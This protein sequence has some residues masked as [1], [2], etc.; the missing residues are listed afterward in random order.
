MTVEYWNSKSG[1]E[2]SI[3]TRRMSASVAD[4]RVD[5]NAS[6]KEW[7]RFEIKPTVSVRSIF[8]PSASSSFLVRGSSVAKSLSSTKADEPV[9]AF[10][11]LDFPAFV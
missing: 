7:G 1:S 9:R 10:I 11:R 4:E 2:Q 6:I 3:T 5:L 8:F